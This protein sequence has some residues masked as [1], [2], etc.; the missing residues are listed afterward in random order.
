MRRCF[1]TLDNKSNNN[2]G[3]AYGAAKLMRKDDSL[4]VRRVK[5]ILYRKQ[6]D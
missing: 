2:H 3:I 4:R 6:K 5:F 1:Y